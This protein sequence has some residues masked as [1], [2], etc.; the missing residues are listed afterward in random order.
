MQVDASSTLRSQHKIHG[1]IRQSITTS[2]VSVFRP[3]FWRCMVFLCRRWQQVAWPCLSY[4]LPSAWGLPNLSCIQLLPGWHAVYLEDV[5]RCRCRGDSRDDSFDS[6]HTSSHA[7]PNAFDLCLGIFWPMGI[8]SWLQDGGCPVFCASCS[9]LFLTL[10]WWRLCSRAVPWRNYHSVQILAVARSN[11]LSWNIQTWHTYDRYDSMYL[12][13]RCSWW[14]CSTLAW[15]RSVCILPIF[16]PH[17]NGLQ[18]TWS[19]GL[20]RVGVDW[21][22]V[23]DV[24]EKRVDKSSVLL[25][26][27]GQ[28]PRSVERRYSAPLIP[29]YKLDRRNHSSEVANIPK[30]VYWR[31]WANLTAI[32]PWNQANMRSLVVDIIPFRANLSRPFQWKNYKPLQM[33]AFF[34]QIIRC[35]LT[36]QQMFFARQTLRILSFISYRWCAVL[37]CLSVALEESQ[38]TLT[39][40]QLL[41]ETPRPHQFQ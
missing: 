15:W 26:R 27:W 40:G 16:H 35:L 19:E 41:G 14:H 21:S 6:C 22:L 8:A 3:S 10:F 13:I 36:A 23:S 39:W 1:T 4:C 2:R 5:D 20:A 25:D 9:S 18:I 17:R 37:A 24:W 34:H 32:D 28:M 38:A 30:A 12:D 31:I 11:L 33:S 7:D 29:P